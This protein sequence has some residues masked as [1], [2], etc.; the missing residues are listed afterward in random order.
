[1]RRIAICD[2][3]PAQARLLSGFVQD[4][5]RDRREP[6]EINLFP[7]GD[8]FW[9]GW[10]GDKAWDILLLDIQMQGTDGLELA[11]R[12]RDSGSRLPLAF[13]TGLAGHMAEGFELDAVHYLV[14]PVSR[15][16]IYLCLDKA[17]QREALQPSLLL[18]GTEGGMFRVLESDVALVEAS[19]HRSLVTL[20]GGEQL[21]VRSGFRELC[22]RL[23][24]GDFIRCHR[25]CLVGLRHIYRLQRDC[26]ILDG[27]RSVPVSRSR[28]QD[29]NSAF[30]SF[31]R[32][33]G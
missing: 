22:A 28:F 6:V 24:E 14:K 31:Y 13:V 27:G 20:A 29:V 2:D 3:E 18:E 1:M 12:L 26:L 15:D 32:Q 33:E 4:W 16:K 30:V 8:A 10:E 17:L 5:S 19:G 25:C 7:S 21:E 23:P 11:R 9:F